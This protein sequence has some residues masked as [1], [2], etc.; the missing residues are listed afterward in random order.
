MSAITRRARTARAYT[1]VKPPPGSDPGLTPVRRFF[2][3]HA[4][5]AVGPSRECDA[6]V[7][8]SSREREL[9]ERLEV[10]DADADEAQRARAVAEGAIEEGARELPD[11]FREIGRASCRE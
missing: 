7:A 5:F 4:V 1:E 3:K 9:A 10:R 2:P 11:R 8:R 6:S